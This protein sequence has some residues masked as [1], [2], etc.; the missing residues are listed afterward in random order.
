MGCWSEC[1]VLGRLS[2]EIRR[3]C[4]IRKIYIDRQISGVGHIDC[5]RAYSAKG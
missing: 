5:A 3:L 4:L 1:G 2:V